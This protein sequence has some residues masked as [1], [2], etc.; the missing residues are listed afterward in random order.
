MELLFLFS[1]RLLGRSRQKGKIAMQK[2]AILPLCC[3]YSS[4]QQCNRERGA[5]HVVV[6]RKCLPQSL[7][8]VTHCQMIF[9]V[10]QAKF[11][12]GHRWSLAFQGSH[13][14]QGL[15]R[16][17]HGQPRQMVVVQKHICHCAIFLSRSVKI[18]K[19]RNQGHFKSD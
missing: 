7:Y 9:Y 14:L 12:S 11:D 16:L 3:F 18:K 5:A 4:F 1:P 8:C 10:I 6:H 17:L 15:I 2:V 19:S 13:P